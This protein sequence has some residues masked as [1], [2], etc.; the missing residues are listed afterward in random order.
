[1][2]MK[3]SSQDARGMRREYN[4]LMEAG[5]LRC[6]ECGAPADPKAVRC[7]HCRVQLATTNCAHCLAMN[8]VGAKHCSQCGEALSREVCVYTGHPCPRCRGK[9][10][11]ITVGDTF[12]RECSRCGGLWVD[13]DAFQLICNRREARAPVLGLAA[14]LPA[15]ATALE[16][17]RYIPCAQCGKLMQ[18]VN[19]A[20]CSGVIVDVCK[21]HGIWFDKDE[22]RRV[23]EFVDHGGLERAREKEK[24]QLEV[25]RRRLKDQ[26]AAAVQPEPEPGY[27]S[28]VEAVRGLFQWLIS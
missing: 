1:M 22:L 25:E 26:A 16:E 21:G 15:Q 13:A 24:E 9:L 2:F 20:R 5:M 4:V 18:R 6:P 10:A 8:F 12:V 27:G 11:L 14:P 23:L 28:A 19:F 7:D 3:Y 17:V